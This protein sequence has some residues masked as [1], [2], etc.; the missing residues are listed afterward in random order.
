MTMVLTGVTE[1]SGDLHL[2]LMPGLPLS[3]W[4]RA[5][6][7]LKTLPWSSEESPY[8]ADLLLWAPPLPT[9]SQENG[10]DSGFRQVP[11]EAGS[12]QPYQML[13]TSLLS[14]TQQQKSKCTPS[15]GSAAPSLDS[16]FLLKPKSS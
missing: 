16:P 14:L 9:H 8:K 3:L 10:Q 2:A 15:T 7:F 4:N 1:S 12:A 13:T 5:K 11:T 6:K